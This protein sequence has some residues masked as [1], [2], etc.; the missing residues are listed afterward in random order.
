MVPQRFKAVVFDAYG[1]VFNVHSVATLAERL[2][3]GAGDRLSQLWRAK[4]LEYMFLRTLMDRYV[5]HDQN[6]ELALTYCCKQLG[7]A[8]G[9][10]ERRQ[11]M[12]AYLWLDPFPDAPA[13][14]DAV[15][16]L[17]RAILS[18]GTPAMLE[19]TTRNAGLA[20]AFDRLLSADKVKL[21]KPHPAVYQLVLDEFGVE[22]GEVAFVTSNYFDVAGAKAFGFGVFWINRSGQLPDELGL[23]PDRML[24][25]LSEL[26]AAL[27]DPALQ[28]AA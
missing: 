22:R 4:Q 28:T 8:C 24:S 23:L 26:P 19:A 20:G 13:A 17:R 10:E 3:P 21:Y 18:I 12:D 6:T 5:P 27:R 1:T 7:L 15:S 25:S 14:L 9:P 16:G 11:L 2:F